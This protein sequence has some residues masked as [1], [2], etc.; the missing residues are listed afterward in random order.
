LH[1]TGFAALFERLYG[2]TDLDRERITDLLFP[3]DELQVQFRTASMK[4]RLIDDSA[5]QPILVPYE[6]GGSLIAILASKGPERWLMRRLQRYTVNIAKHH[7]NTMFAR[8]DVIPLWRDSYFSL[9]SEALYDGA[10][11]VVLPTEN[12]PVEDL[13]I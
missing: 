5:Y 8:G 3:G 11:G 6:E 13:V 7:F 12:L 10:V 1:R 2:S 4:F 9:T